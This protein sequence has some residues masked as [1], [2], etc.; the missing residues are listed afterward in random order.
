MQPVSVIIPCFNA[1]KTLARALDSCIA[2]ADAAQIIVVD[3][4]SEDASRDVA[5]FYALKDSR[6]HLVRMPENGG[7]A[8]ARNL[9]AQ[10]AVSPL[11]A[12]LDADDEYLPG[13]LNGASAVLQSN[14]LRP[15]AHLDVDFSKFPAHILAHPDFERHAAYMS[16]VVTSSLVVRSAV[17]AALGGFP[18][19]ETY[20]TYGGEDF[21]FSKALNEIYGCVRLSDRKRVRMHYH[22]NSHVA[23]YFLRTMG[24]LHTPTEEL[25]AINRSA[26]QFLEHARSAVWR[27]S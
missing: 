1:V 10:H 9:G 14:P 6:V 12:F 15:A 5:A 4:A 22:E 26:E 18:V 2:Q 11:L 23:R 20:R 21:A 3:D 19:D 8:R 13:A 27:T 16:D 24:I 17:F 7:P 25:E